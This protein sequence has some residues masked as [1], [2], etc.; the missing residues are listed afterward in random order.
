MW[1]GGAGTY[2]VGDEFNAADCTAGITATNVVVDGAGEYSV[3][4]DFA[5]GND[6]LTFAALGL[7]SGEDTYPGAIINITSITVDGKE[8]ELI[9]DP[10]TSSDDGHCTRVNLL[11]EWVPTPPDDARTVDGDTSNISAVIIDKNELV[12]IKNITVNFELITE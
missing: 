3:S 10:Y 11:N 7:A 8:L 9:A 1:N 6:G 12:G 4:L 2:S 5:G